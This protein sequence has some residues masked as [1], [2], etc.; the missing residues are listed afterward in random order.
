MSGNR[1]L[2]PRKPEFWILA[3]VTATIIGDIVLELLSGA[4][5]DWRLREWVTKPLLLFIAIGL[6]LGYGPKVGKLL[7]RGHNEAAVEQMND[8]DSAPVLIVFVSSNPTGGFTTAIKTFSEAANSTLK[9]I[10]LIYS[11][12]E[13]SEENA[14]TMYGQIN[15]GDKPYTAHMDG[16]QA[17]FNNMEQVKRIAGTA[18][19]H[20]LELEGIEANDIV[21]DIT[22]GN[23]ISSAG[24]VLAAMEV[25]DV[26]ATYIPQG[27]DRK[28]GNTIK[29]VNIRFAQAA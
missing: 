18:I 12:E 2:N 16:L 5:V 15:E 14:K 20:A 7:R 13:K 23:A 28:P 27:A 9:H 19:R 26:T 17:D 8:I 3:A 21:I 22:G 6:T 29:R 24:A 25:D 4:F 1:L 10:F 11:T